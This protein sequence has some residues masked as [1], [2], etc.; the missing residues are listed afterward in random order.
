MILPT[1]SKKPDNFVRKTKNYLKKPPMTLKN[2]IEEGKEK[3]QLVMW[4]FSA[5][6]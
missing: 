4:V 5:K 6:M 1:S 3:K 2:Y